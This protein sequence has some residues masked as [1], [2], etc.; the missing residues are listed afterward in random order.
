MKDINVYQWDLNRS[1]AT[2]SQAVHFAPVVG[3]VEE[4]LVETFESL[5][6]EARDAIQAIKDA[7]ITG[8]TATLLE[9][10]QEPTASIVN[11]VLELG[12][13]KGE[14]GDKGEPGNSA[15]DEH[16]NSLIDAKL[17]VITNGSY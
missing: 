2:A 4:A 13:P 10:G 1:V 9:A 14:K 16:V 15:S 6:Q 12:I 17:G 7:T 3:D 11:G 5:T 8:A